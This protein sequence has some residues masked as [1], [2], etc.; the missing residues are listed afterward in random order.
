MLKKSV[1]LG[2]VLLALMLTGAAQARVSASEA[3]NLGHSLTPFGAEAAGNGKDVSTGL[4][5]PDWTGGITGSMIPK[6][7]THAGQH[8]PDPFHEDKVIFTIDAQ[9]MGQYGDKLSTGVQALL[10]LYPDTFHLKVFRSRRSTSAPEFVY[11][12]TKKNA[13]TAVLADHGNGVKDAFGGIPFPIL[14]GSSSERALEAVWNHI[15]RWRG[16]YVVRRMAEAA[17]QRDGSF[18]PYVVQQEAYFP[19][20]DPKLSYEKIDNTLLYYLTFTKAPPRLAGGA[21]LVRDPLNQVKEP[22]QAWGYNAGLRRV[23][24]APNI[25]YD[26][27][28][29]EADGLM[30]A[31]E[32][33]MYNGSPNKYNWKMVYDHPVERFIPYN[34]YKLD[35]PNLTYKQI[36]KPGHI[37]SDLVRW[38]LHRVWVVEGDLKKDER[39]IYHKRVF[40]ID[41]DNWQIDEADLYD[42]RNQ[43]WRVSLGYTMNF[44]E[45]PDQWAVIQSHMDLRAKRYNVVGMT[46]EEDTDLDFSRPVPNRRYFSPA[47]L[48]R[49][50]H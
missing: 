3:A 48:S 2:S 4:G 12:N 38:E 44:Y 49:R 18:V 46:N 7:Y 26:M 10:K 40:Y 37:D 42:S 19:Y 1:L 32:V 36:I 43:L 35:D 11:K 31:D 41:A 27:P 34:D 16:V 25:A 29:P 15:L 50:G 5:I 6:S 14:S 17:V 30:T 13:T 24:R 39:H 20:Y 8:H 9:N 47:S 21:I 22:R 23:R 45:V 33:D 28:I